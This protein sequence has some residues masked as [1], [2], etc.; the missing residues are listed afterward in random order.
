MASN[1]LQVIGLVLGVLAAICTTV[2]VMLPE[3]RRNDY[4]GEVIEAVMRHQGK[5]PCIATYEI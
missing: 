3:W 1:A 2:A 4:S 5:P